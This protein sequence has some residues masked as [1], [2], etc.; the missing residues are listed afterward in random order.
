VVAGELVP[1]VAF[2]AAGGLVLG[3][4][5]ARASLGPLGLRLLTGQAA[6]PAAVVPWAVVVPAAALPV[7]AAAAVA[8]AEARRGTR[9]DLARA[10]R[11]PEGR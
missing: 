3:V 7:L 2:A 10:L 6:D 5:L 4:L 1:P 11:S 8:L 9:A